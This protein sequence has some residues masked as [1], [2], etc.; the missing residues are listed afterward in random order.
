M[1]FARKPVFAAAH[2]SERLSRRRCR[3]LKPQG[4]TALWSLSSRNFRTGSKT[5]L[6]TQ[7]PSHTGGIVPLQRFASYLMLPAL[8]V[9]K[10]TVAVRVTKCA[11]QARNRQWAHGGVENGIEEILQIGGSNSDARFYG[12]GFAITI[13]ELMP[14]D[15]RFWMYSICHFVLS[16]NFESCNGLHP[17]T[18]PGLRS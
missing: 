10:R 1:P 6:S 8:R 4:R 9:F 2:T 5:A 18:S 7:S 15:E 11:I 17:P 3:W 13:S 14:Q 12:F 16:S